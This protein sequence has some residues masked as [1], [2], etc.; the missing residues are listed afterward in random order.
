MRRPDVITSK[1]N[2]W[3]SF[4]PIIPDS[5]AALY[6]L[7]GIISFVTFWIATLL[8]TRH[9]AIKTGSIRYWILIS[10][11]LVYFASQFLISYVED[12]NPLKIFRIENTSVY[13]YL[14]NLFL[15]TVRIVGGFALFAI[16]RS[17][18]HLRLGNSIIIAGI[19]LIVLAG[20]NSTL[21]IIMTNFPPW[22]VVS[23]SFSIVG[24][25]C[26]LIGLDSAAF[27]VASDSSLRRFIQRLPSKSFDL[28]RSL[29]FTKIQDMIANRVEGLSDDIY[30]EI[31]RN[32]LFTS[33]SL[34]LIA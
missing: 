30:D 22:G 24:S 4:S 32:N 13:S 16:S 9:Y 5:L 6:Q 8:L 12:L 14:Y 28:F 3:T 21:T 26:L 18:T 2:T 31:D 11:P 20:V 17:V 27:Y 10:I 34:N 29:S 15:N 1:Y 19:G 25:Y 33:A 23:I 7:V